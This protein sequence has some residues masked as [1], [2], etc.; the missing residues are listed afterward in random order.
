[1]RAGVSKGG[2]DLGL[3]KTASASTVNVGDS[4][5]YELS[6]TN[7][8]PDPALTAEV[9]DLLPSGV[10][11][12]SS[13]GPGTYEPTSGQWIF[14]PGNP[15]SVSTLTINVQAASPATVVNNATILSSTPADTNSANNFAYVMVN[16]NAAPP[17]TAD[18]QITKTVNTNTV[19]VTDSVQFT[20]TVTN[21]GPDTASNIVVNDLLPSGLAYGTIDAPVTTTYNQN[22]GVWTIPILP[23]GDGYA[24]LIDATATV[25]GMFV[26]TAT[27]TSSTP[28]DTN[29]LNNSASASVTVNPAALPRAD[30]QISKTV[31]TNVVEVGGLVTFSIT[32]TN[33]GP[34][35][36]SNIVVTDLLPGGLTYGIVDAPS[37]STY[38]ETN[39]MW[40]IP[41]LPAGE[42]FELL[43]DANATVPGV[44]TNTATRTS[45]TP[46][47]TNAA[48]DSASAGVTV[49]PGA[50][51][52][53]DLQITKTVDTNAVFVG[54]SVQFTITVTNLGPDTA[55]NIVVTDLLPGG[56]TYG[57]VDTPGESTYDET[58]GLW[59]VP[60]LPAGEGLA[61][62]IDANVTVP[63]VFTNT[64]TLT[65]STPTDTN[66]AN[67]SARAKVTATLPLIPADL[68]VA[69]TVNSTNSPIGS[70]VA[71]TIQL[72][73]LGPSNVTASVVTT[74][75][76]PTGYQY[77]SDNS[78]G[79]YSA[80]TCLWTLSGLAA[81]GSTN[82]V[83]TTLA[84][85]AGAFTNTASVAVPAGYT[86]PNTNNNTSSV[87]AVTYPV[88]TLSGYV[89]GCQTNGPALPFINVTLSGA[90]N[91][92]AVTD[93]NGFFIF[94]NLVGGSYTVTPVQAA[95]VFSPT[96]ATLTL[97][98]NT[99][100]SPFL[101]S[102]S[103]IR[104]K[105]TYGTNGPGLGGLLVELSGLVS[106]TTLTDSNGVYAF[107]NTLPGDYFVAPT[108]TNGFVF[109]PTNALL[110]I[111]DTNCIAQANF[112][113]SNR[114][115]QLVALEV[116][117]VVQDWSNSVTLI[118]AK[119][120]FVRAYL[121]LP[122]DGPS[123]LAQGARLLGSGAGGALGDSPLAPYA[124]NRSP[125]YLVQTT[126]ATKLRGNFNSSL[127]FQLPPAWSTNGAITLQFVC[128]NNLTVIPT[129]TVSTNSS[130]KVSF[131]PTVAPPIKFFGFNWTNY[132][133]NA[134]QKVDMT[135]YPTVPKRV[136][137]VY[138]VPDI[139]ADRAVLAPPTTLLVPKVI[140][141]TIPAGDSNVW[142]W[143]LLNANA[144][145]LQI[146]SLDWLLSLR[147]GYTN[148]IY[149]GVLGGPS[150]GTLG[151]AGAYVNNENGESTGAA[152]ISSSFL[153]PTLYG[154]GSAR[155]TIPHEIGHN[156]GWPHDVNYMV[157]GYLMEDGV[158]YTNVALGTCNQAPVSVPQYPLFQ[159][160]PQPLGPFQPALGPMAKGNNSIIY[161]LDTFTVM[162]ATNIN[163][164]AD[165]NNCFD[166]MSY[167][168]GGSPLERW[169]SSST[170][171][172]FR[173]S[174]NTT[175]AAPPPAPAAGPDREW[176][177]IRG[178]VDSISDVGGFEP[179]W[180]VSSTVATPPPGPP[181][182]EYLAILFDANGNVIED[183]PFQPQPFI[184]EE[185]EAEE[186]LFSIPVLANSA[187]QQVQIEDTVS[188]DIIADI[189]APTNLPGVSS[190]LLYNTNGGAFTGAGPLVVKWT[191]LDADPN[192]QLAYTI[193]F[194]SD[195][196]NSWDTL[197]LD[198]PGESYQIDSSFLNATTQ[199]LVRILAS[200][201]F[202]TSAPADSSPF[203]I[204]NHAPNV[205]INEPQG[206]T[207]FIADSQIYL[208][209]S[210]I[211]PQDGPLDGLSVQWSS[212]LDGLLGDG[213][214]LDFEADQLSEGAHVITVTA[215]DGEGLSNSAQVT[216]SIIRQ[217]PPALGIQ[218]T[219]NLILLSWPASVT[220]YVLQSTPSLAPGVWSSLT[221][222]SVIV[223]I[224]QTVTLG[225]SNTN[226]FFRLSMK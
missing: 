93:T 215:T 220:N 42:G 205:T 7:L 134:F 20:V 8:G 115:V 109:T 72:Q 89:R 66:A 202:N 65:S 73:N 226:Q 106:K 186:D 5:S 47:D 67:N 166:L 79:A 77:V 184:I 88:F 218:Y 180:T 178:F 48:N 111:A 46:T 143:A 183:I 12:V 163:P 207:V 39:G 213:A 123:V 173:A 174:I 154:M 62:L 192:A 175:F 148:W 164:V 177:F 144:K 45:S 84:T 18:L 57:S 194:S 152:N 161:G 198:W 157:L 63:G 189:V 15:G 108:P 19:A 131:V 104:G 133:S 140:P 176:M 50:P 153:Q 118:Q 35:T 222:E 64:A 55:S 128:T 36:S 33:L 147:Y 167:C 190:V 91:G 201:G 82:L 40:M 193:Q 94:T 156:L 32:V 204:P 90:A 25:P 185:T 99:T 52:Q 191:G 96:N 30:L 10:L 117:Q 127:N 170:Y 195:G 58:N 68:K 23:V 1:M 159:R 105:V 149:C 29:A 24:L 150:K 37:P 203:T 221:N 119:K 151:W 172:N 223:D 98:S 28:T 54:D 83:I 81:N 51:P 141:P 103:Q 182:G 160:I 110:K 61:L 76:L 169:A 11:F 86:D 142:D 196:G 199:G 6:V 97:S 145:L 95:N 209:A 14:T 3:G 60:V 113:A 211:D 146:K 219:N 200:D 125:D 85:T 137:S 208:D 206:G 74:D 2:I 92:V 212:S 75:C 27:L 4:F 22:N 9:S 214:V 13:S 26:N 138:P 16:I 43:I 130:V 181:A 126:D 70:L 71:F 129:N 101:S 132:A 38:D 41:V 165:P 112:Q 59:M 31:N 87:V 114:V 216:I 80:G 107:T 135:I 121:Q 136:V 155:Q 187:V 168:R 120:T 49:Y 116:V 224:N 225:L 210:A 139:T 100:L 21:L 102:L 69:K 171:T 158:T 179:F 188:G 197:D 34:N 44:F 162:N 122:T 56:L 17:P 124:P 217:S 53:A 78:G